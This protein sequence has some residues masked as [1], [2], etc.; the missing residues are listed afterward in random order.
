MPIDWEQVPREFPALS[1]WTHLNTA[2]FGQTPKR[3]I[4]AMMRHMVYRDELACMDFLYW[5]DDLDRI[6]VKCARLV[7]CHAADIAFV[8]SSSHG[9]AL[10]MHGLDWQRGDEVLTLEDEFP[11]QLYAAAALDRYGVRLRT[12]PWPGFY[13]SVNKRTRVVVLSSVNYATGFRPPL[14][15]ISAFLA[16]R[17]VLLYVD[18]SQSVGA[19]EFNVARVRPSV[20]SVNAYKW[21]MSPNGAG[22]LYIAPELRRRLPPIVTGWRSD[23]NWRN[24][25]QLNHGVPRFSESAERYEGG[26]P[27]FPSIYAMGAVI[28]MLLKLGPRNVEARVL[29]LAAKVRMMLRELGAEINGDDSQIVTAVLPGCD[30]ETLEAELKERRILTSVRHGR[31]RISTHVYNTE[32]DIEVLRS[33]LVDL[34]EQ[35]SV[36]CCAGERS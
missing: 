27:P 23:R 24:V 4:Q 1:H 11:N 26:M 13:E 18:G 21:L 19:L 9:M 31:L 25:Q 14:E 20:L 16:P 36:A 8:P 30:S 2:T 12:A 15:E 3:A 34:Q 32:H 10:L 5:F 6:R 22:F 7:N 35:H 28:D 29:E 33:A 17:R